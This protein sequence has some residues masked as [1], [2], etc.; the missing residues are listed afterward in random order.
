MVCDAKGEAR[1]FSEQ[2]LPSTNFWARGLDFSCV[3]PWNSGASAMRA[4]TAISRRHII[5]ASHYALWPGIRMV[6]VGEDGGVCPCS[7]TKTKRI[8]GTDIM[9]GL[10]DY[11]LTPN[12]KPAQVMPDDWASHVGSVTNF[13]VVTFNR[14]EHLLYSE[15]TVVLTNGVPAG[16]ENQRVCETNAPIEIAIGGE[17]RHSVAECRKI[18]VPKAAIQRNGMI[19]VGD[20]GNPAFMIY[21]GEPVLMYCLFRGGVG[22]GPVMIICV[23]VNSQKKGQK[24]EGGKM[25]NFRR[26]NSGRWTMSVH[27]DG[28]CFVCLD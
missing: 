28:K 12:I 9:I 26:E 23:P 18:E 20:S 4:G 27:I 10:L 2:I 8:D 19:R 21:K 14:K 15:L 6:F 7:I 17:T 22:H 13:P 3:S 1:I 24:M 11:E 25:G 5:F 16:V